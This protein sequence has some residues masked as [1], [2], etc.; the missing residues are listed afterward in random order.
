MDLTVIRPFSLPAGCLLASRSVQHEPGDVAG[1]SMLFE[2]SVPDFYSLKQFLL[3]LTFQ[4][5]CS[6]LSDKL[7]S[8][9]HAFFKT[10]DSFD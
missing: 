6:V 4:R 5:P 2:A 3:H 7:P 9:V 10:V 8:R 1:T